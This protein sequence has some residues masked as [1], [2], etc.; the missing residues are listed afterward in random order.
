V[1]SSWLK[2]PDAS[3]GGTRRNYSPADRCLLFWLPSD[4]PDPKPDPIDAA[5]PVPAIAS[6]PGLEGGISDGI[7]RYAYPVHLTDREIAW[8]FLRLDELSTSR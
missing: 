7:S 1:R 4:N 6:N 2:S 5:F 8:L 3:D